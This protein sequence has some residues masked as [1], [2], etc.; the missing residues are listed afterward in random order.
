MAQGQPLD[1]Q[2]LDT[3]K[4]TSELETSDAPE[5]ADLRILGY[6]EDAELKSIAWGLVDGGFADDELLDVLDDAAD[7]LGDTR[8]AEEIRQQLES[9]VLI[10]KITSSAG[11]SWRTRMAETVRLLARLRQLFPPHM[12]NQ[13]WRTAATL[14]SDYRFVARH[15]LFPDR[16]V[17][18]EEFLREALG[19]ESG[20]VRDALEAMTLGERG[21]AP[22]QVRA[23]KT[24]L[25]HIGSA[26]P[27][28]TL[29]AAGTGSGK[30]KAVYLP[31]L[32]HLSSLGTSKA[33]TKM[34]SLYPRNELL[35]DQLQVVIKELRLL[36]ANVGI[37]LTV[38]AFFG[39]TPFGNETPD[40]WKERNG[41][42]TCPFL[43]CPTCDS[44][45]YWFDDGGVGG[46]NCSKCSDRVLSDELLLSRRQQQGT[47]P[48]VLLTTVETLNR[49]LGNDHSR[50]LFGVGHPQGLRPS[51]LLL[52][53]VHTY[54]GL[55]GAQ[56]AHLVRRWRHAVGEPVHSVGLSATITDGATFFGD[57]TSTHPGNV[58]VVEPSASELH[59]EGKEYLIALRGNPASG[60][61]LLSTTIQTSM[62]LR[63][64]LDRADK[65]VSNGA[66]GTKLFAFTDNLDVTNRFAH[67]LRRA[68]GQTDRGRPDPKRP[69]GSLANLRHRH[70]PDYRDRVDD[71]QAWDL[72][73]DLHHTLDTTQVM[74][75]E[76]TSSQDVGFKKSADIVVATSSLEVGLDDDS[77]GAVIQHK[78]PR[79]A[80]SF[81][82][83]RGR[84][85]RTREMRP[86]TAVVLSDYGQDRMAFQA[87][88]DL[89]DPQLRP[90]RL[91]TLNRYVLRIQATHALLDWL[92]D[93]LR[94]G[95][96]PKGN[97]WADLTGP[98]SDGSLL[99][100]EN[101]RQRLLQVLVD[102][103][104]S[105][106]MRNDFHQFLSKALLIGPTEVDQLLWAPPR[107][108]L[109]TVVPTLIRR[110][111][112]EWNRASAG[113]GDYDVHGTQLAP[114]LPDFLPS[115][116]FADLLLPEVEIIFP[117][118]AS[119]TEA[120][121]VE[122]A[123]SEFSPG[124]VT[125]RF[126]V[127]W[128]G[129]RLWIPVGS[130]DTNVEDVFDTD[131]LEVVT[132]DGESS[133]I[134]VLRPWRIHPVTPDLAVKSSSNGRPI[135][136]SSF[137]QFGQ[138]VER[139]TPNYMGLDD[140][141]PN[142]EFFF[143]KAGTH[144]TVYRFSIGSTGVIN[145]GQ[146][147]EMFET[148]FVDESGPV[149]IGYR[150]D[151]D[152]VCFEARDPGGWE[153]VGEDD[154]KL[155]QAL[156]KDWFK[157]R[158]VEHP[159]LRGL[160][161]VFIRDW[162]AELSL[163]AIVEEAVAANSS[164]HKGVKNFKS[165]PVAD[166]L[167]HVLK[168]VFQSVDPT[169]VTGAEAA[170]EE[171]D[172]TKLHREIVEVASNPVVEKAIR[173]ATSELVKP[174]TQDFEAWLRDR[175]LSTVAGA[176]AHAL[177][178]LREEVSVDDL[179]VDTGPWVEGAAT[180]RVS[181]RK[182]GGV[183]LV[184]ALYDAYADDPLR[185][186]RLLTGVVDVSDSEVVDKALTRFTTLAS[187]DTDI[188]TRLG[189]V[190]DAR[191]HQDRVDRWRELIDALEEEGLF[192]T[193]SVQVAL[194]TRFL[195]PGIS[196]AT[197]ALL[198]ELL[199]H[200]SSLE[201]SL[202]IE[203]ELRTFA[204][205][206]SEDQRLDQ[207]LGLSPPNDADPRT[208]R[209]NAFLSLLWPRG[210]WLRTRPVELWRS[211]QADAPSPDRSLLAQRLEVPDEAVQSEHDPEASELA[212]I[213]EQSGVARVRGKPGTKELRDSVLRSLV[214]PVEVG[215]LELFPR[216]TGLR[217]TESGM[218]LELEV[219]EMMG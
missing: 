121:G 21:W 190:R 88:D 206:I 83:R 193:P 89:F 208:W 71:G 101:R 98:K 73:L 97:V 105:T 170:D 45:L 187:T 182:P 188:P 136:R 195:R 165:R 80:A 2:V 133:P 10:S 137:R 18:S 107:G 100:I 109:S 210:S 20:P 96:A 51:L 201:R 32:A 169:K 22:F 44:D 115:A 34:V 46:L 4:V 172:V 151:T 147:R 186:W 152:A 49:Q 48:D 161:S 87:W 5:D 106:E 27:T 128:T 204:H 129:E 59:P 159:D 113:T 120:M 70:Y 43:R 132:P 171:V 47:P 55:T 94:K 3:E 162:L 178:L 191:S 92:A 41:H 218:S 117:D 217:R 179:I 166:M 66:F 8:S 131:P 174:T 79:D 160:A 130:P 183:G 54:S 181:E 65:P 37:A 203:I 111:Q 60:T 13:S 198:D 104:D 23:T 33:W 141:V 95:Q 123:L 110:L 1:S 63:R 125:H 108:V 185:F 163:A 157:H 138:P 52:D 7:V 75:I 82:Q 16:G 91:P 192:M 214:V 127:G 102:L 77:V 205:L 212:A 199:C 6:L 15:R 86:W 24:I 177:A 189:N 148:R 11:S 211:F 99:G 19:D 116:S 145:R 149:G 64:C 197:D 215:V 209:F 76:R 93:Q 57:L 135:W 56:V 176:L 156:L 175:Y 85:G 144:L 84:A 134:R 112:S 39:D 155:R 38:G 219:P 168:V 164:L 158:V 62:L 126:A 119:N 42:R 122:S 26:E 118:S 180:I 9:R 29:V 143:H 78:A 81:V 216:V 140:L 90:L 17:S 167:D 196:S 67:F 50:G 31:A 40:N 153:A 28:A 103:L 142:V 35:K 124:K 30:T 139:T 154:P 200:W 150:I 68:E 184:E 14:V 194:S 173:E 69:Q 58:E 202:G 213:L 53:E 25:Q 146:D 12:A 36:K 74:S 72:C 114:P 61:A 207:S